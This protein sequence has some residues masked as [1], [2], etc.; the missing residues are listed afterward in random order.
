ALRD[1]EFG[2]FLDRVASEHVLVFFD[3]CYSGGLARSLP[4]GARPS[5]GTLDLFR[6]FSLEGRLVLSA[7]SETQDAFESPTLGHGV[8]THF[9]LEGL[10]GSADLNGDTQV[11]AWEIY[12]YVLAEV[13]PFVREERGA[14]Q[15]PQIVGEGDVRV[16]VAT[17]PRPLVPDFSFAPT[18]PFAGGPVAFLD[19]TTGETA[20]REWSFGDGSTSTDLNPTHVY[21]EPGDFRVSLVVTS[22]AGIPFEASIEIPIAPA[23][24]I[25]GEE[26]GVWIVSLGSRNGIRAGHRLSVL[27]ADSLDP[28]GTLEVTELLDADAAACRITDSTAPPAV[29]DLVRPTPSA[30]LP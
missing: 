27:K 12:E 10:R 19:E 29:G 8:F 23:G 3:G 16:L 30:H 20:S 13:P 11:T 28:A 15:I 6:D 17:D 7:T 5:H 22:P 1:D 24:R 25:T 26:E 2:R 21:S 9:V 18:V 4:S 14:D